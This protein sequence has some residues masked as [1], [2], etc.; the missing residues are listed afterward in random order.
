MFDQ[1]GFQF[2]TISYIHYSLTFLFVLVIDLGADIDTLCVVPK[3]VARE[4]FFE[5]MHE[6]LRNRPEVTELTAV[7]DAF[8]PVIKMK[9]SE[10][11]VSTL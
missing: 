9:F 10:I 5:V 1:E 11:P 2:I 7:P 8:T 6:M 3:N 4:D